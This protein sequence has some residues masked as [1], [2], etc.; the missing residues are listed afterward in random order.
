MPC[1]PE[2]GNQP[3]LAEGTPALRIIGTKVRAY[4]V[5]DRKLSI[6]F[7]PRGVEQGQTQRSWYGMEASVVTWKA[8]PDLPG[9]G[10]SREWNI[11][12]FS[13]WC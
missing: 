8:S 3:C 1:L 12:A 13:W 9:K 4:Y 5:R 6:C 11:L 7:W 10:N 2:L